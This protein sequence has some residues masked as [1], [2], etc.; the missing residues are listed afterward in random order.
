MQNL[1]SSRPQLLALTMIV[2]FALP[3]AQAFAI[4]CKLEPPARVKID[5]SGVVTATIAVV[6][7]TTLKNVKLCTVIPDANN[8]PVLALLNF[9]WVSE[10]RV[11]GRHSSGRTWQ[12]VTDGSVIRMRAG[13][14]F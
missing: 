5:S 9:W 10:G 13:R 7:S 8:P 1:R 12:R 4:T 6:G 2:M 3:A 11:R 14:S